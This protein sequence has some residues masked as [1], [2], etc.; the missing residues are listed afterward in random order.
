MFFSSAVGE[1]VLSKGIS[2]T[3]GQAQAIFLRN[4]DIVVE[5]AAG[6]GKTA[7]L[8]QRFME[9]LKENPAW[10]PRDI[11]V[12]TFTKKA[13]SELRA[14]IIKNIDDLH[15]YV[16]VPE[17]SIMTIHGLCQQILKN[18]PLEAGMCPGFKLIDE[19]EWMFHVKQYLPSFIKGLFKK[20]GSEMR[21][22]LA[23]YGYKS[24]INF[25]LSLSKLASI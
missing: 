1:Y 11:L 25:F 24:L 19:D 18:Y 3:E 20:Q 23:F 5:A 4:K 8:S 14:R 13:V 7:V 21:V 9:L 22:L 16:G 12:L 2:W 10:L 6:S 17:F 15:T